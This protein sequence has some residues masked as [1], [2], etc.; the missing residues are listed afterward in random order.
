MLTWSKKKKNNEKKIM[1]KKN[2]IKTQIENV[3]NIEP[4]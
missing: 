4:K 1:Q 3:S 2:S